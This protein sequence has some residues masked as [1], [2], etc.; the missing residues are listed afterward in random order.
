ML[1]TELW[2]YNLAGFPA[3]EPYIFFPIVNF[4][5]SQNA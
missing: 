2:K 1:T 3:H 4:V 5:S